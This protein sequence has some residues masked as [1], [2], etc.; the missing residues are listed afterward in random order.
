MSHLIMLQIQEN[1]ISELN[2]DAA[3]WG[4]IALSDHWTKKSWTKLF[5]IWNRVIS[6]NHQMIFLEVQ[7]GVGWVCGRW[8]L[9]YNIAF[10]KPEGREDKEALSDHW[11][12]QS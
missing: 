4:H 11:T 6:S 9:W 2:I 8:K 5:S 10:V 3:Q 12:K 7:G 1:S